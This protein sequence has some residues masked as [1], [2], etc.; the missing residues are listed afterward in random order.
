[1]N[2]LFF[3]DNLPIMR[4][5]VP[6]A[7]VDL[8]YLDP[9][10]NSSRDYTYYLGRLEKMRIKRRSLRLRTHGIGTNLSMSSSSMTRIM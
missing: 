2:T 9:P 10:F 1:M 3:G 4:E 7:T 5:Y 6:K 8:V